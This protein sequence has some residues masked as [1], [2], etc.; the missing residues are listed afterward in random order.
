MSSNYTFNDRNIARPGSWQQRQLPRIEAALA[1]PRWSYRTTAGIAKDLGLTT[2]EVE[3]L[4]SAYPQVARPAALTD[5]EGRPLY[6][7]PDRPMPWKERL[8]RVRWVLAH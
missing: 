3:S 5:T 6:A 8:E 7:S 2:A 4:L 1:D